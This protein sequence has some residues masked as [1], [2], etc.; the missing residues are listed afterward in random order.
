M[1]VLGSLCC[2]L[3][4]F[5]SGTYSSWSWQ[6]FV[7]AVK[8]FWSAWRLKKGS[9]D[10]LLSWWDRAKERI[11]GLAISHCKEKAMHRNLSRTVFVALAD[12]LKSKIDQGHV[13]LLPIFQNVSSKIAALDL[14]DARGAKV[15]SRVKWAEEGET[16]SRYFLKLEKKRG[17]LDWISAM[18]NADGVVVSDL[19]GICKSWMDFYSSLFSAC[20]V[21]GNVQADLLSNVSSFLSADRA[22]SCE[23]YL[24]TSEVYTALNGMARGKSPGSDG[25]PMEF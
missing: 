7:A 25:L 1:P 15:R 20:D 2:S 10:S 5:N 3:Q 13:S 11:K 12:H 17:A 23:G 16:S 4:G 9:F 18:K 21:D 14:S 19:D 24:T 8:V 6:D 22:G